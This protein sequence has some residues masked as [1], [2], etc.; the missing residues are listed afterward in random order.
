MFIAQKDSIVY[1]KVLIGGKSVV[2]ARVINQVN[3]I[4]TAT[5]YLKPEDL[6]SFSPD[7]EVTLQISDAPNAGPI[8]TGLVSSVNFSNMNG[9]LTAGIDLKHKAKHLDE[10][11]GLVPGLVPGGNYDVDTLIFKPE[12]SVAGESSGAYFS[13]DV[14]KP[15]P[16]AICGTKNTGLIGWLNSV[17]PSTCDGFVE[18]DAGDKQKTISIL[19]QI[20]ADSEPM[21]FTYP[22]LYRKTSQYCEG[23][24]NRATTS[25]TIWDMLMVILGSF[26]CCLVCKPDGK[27]IITPNW[28]GVKSQGNAIDSS[29]ITK[30][31]LSSLTPRNIKQ[32]SIIGSVG[33][34]IKGNKMKNSVMGQY[35]E[36]GVSVGGAMFMSAPGWINDIHVKETDIG[37]QKNA[38][39]KLAQCILYKIR[40]SAVAMCR[41]FSADE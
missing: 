36:E 22:G 18:V 23:I 35:S 7:Q 14:S 40:L 5:I 27:V 1:P 32:C 13:F 6:S 41:L 15:F 11:S 3:E 29:S 26:D 9:Q 17:Y 31:D 39:D 12:D 37:T 25:S 2:S 10:A 20:K 21:M 34:T 33:S 4:P 24:L 16:E 8:F 28:C 30:F 38:L 19:E